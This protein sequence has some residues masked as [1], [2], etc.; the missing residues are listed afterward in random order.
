MHRS[1][2]A[3]FIDCFIVM[4]VLG[5]AGCGG[6]GSNSSSA[7]G[8]SVSGVA[9]TGLPITPSMNGV[10][11]IQDS[12][13]PAH[14]AST[15]TDANGNYSFSA[16]QIA[17]WTAPL[18]LEINYKIAGVNYSLHSAATATDLMGSNATINITPLTDLV[19]ANVAGDIAANVFK[20]QSTF[21]AKLTSTALA[22]G[23]TSL[24]IQLKNV[25]T[26]LG[27]SASLDLLRQSFKADGTGVDALLDSLK[28]TQDPVTKTA[29]IIDRLDGSQ[30]VNS[31]TS[32]TTLALPMPVMTNVSDLQSL[33][34]Y[35]AS[36]SSEMAQFPAP[37][38]PKLTTF[39]DVANFMQDGRSLASFLK[40]VTT[41]PGLLGGAVSFND[42][43][44]D[45]VP[46]WVTKVP[47]GATAYQVHFTVL[48]GGMPSSRK[49]FIVYKNT[50]TNLWA[51][52]GNQRI[53]KVRI[54]ALATD[55][56]SYGSSTANTQQYCTGLWPEIVDQG[57]FNLAYAVV[58][59]PGLPVAGLLLFASATRSNGGDF[60]LAA[61]APSTYIGASTAPMTSNVK[62]CG[63][64]SLF[65][66][67]D[68]DIAAVAASPMKY[69]IDLYQT[70]NLN[71]PLASYS[72][73]LLAAPLTSAQLSSALFTSGV[74]SNPAISPATLV[75][76]G[77]TTI[78]WAEPALG[79]LYANSLNLWGGGS[80]A[81]PPAVS[82]TFDLNGQASSALVTYPAVSGGT[83]AGINTSYMDSLF[84]DYWTSYLF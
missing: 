28:V 62:A 27:V 16:D 45:T 12:A 41:D 57:G 73:T 76:G 14:T 15:A 53:A 44:L 48:I 63:F 30:V 39:F 79:G 37:T 38:D 13:L 58:K 61:G 69:S 2:L 22:A 65:P 47:T 68:T 11:T 54:K 59:G 74:S 82:L 84:R 72:S 23:V 81:N 26:A 9:A 77:T 70:G 31:L 29:T 3:R 7:S 8:A 40:Q 50:S 35:F 17:G 25:L 6:G 56:Q 75:Q 46:S 10:V 36:I 33:I 67:Q 60:T 18:M 24:D 83:Y 19:I 42:I 5:L 51:I 34:T 80:G 1:L 66:L 20:N 55:S 78:S 64:N 21:A 43:V 49:D 4:I 71:T 32:S 52:L